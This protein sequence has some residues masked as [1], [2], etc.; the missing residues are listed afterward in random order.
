MKC[1]NAQFSAVNKILAAIIC[2]LQF[3]LT[4]GAVAQSFNSIYDFTGIPDGANPRGN[5]AA[6]STGN[7]YGTTEAGGVFDHG[8]VFELSPPVAPGSPWTETILYSF[9]GGSDGESPLGG[10]AID[11]HGNLWGTTPYGDACCGTVFKL[12]APASGDQWEFRTIHTFTGGPSDGSYPVAGVVV[13]STGNVYGITQNGGS[14]TS[15]CAPFQSG[16]GTVFKITGM[17]DGSFTETILWNFGGSGDGQLPESTPIIDAAGNLYGTTSDGGRPF[18]GRGHGTAYMLSPSNGTWAETILFTFHNRQSPGRNP[19]GALVLDKQ[20][21]FWGTSS[22]GPE[23]APGCGGFGC[24]TIFRLSPSNG[25]YIGNPLY[26]FTNQEDGA[27]PQYGLLLDGSTSTFYGTVPYSSP[28]PD[29]GAIF[30]VAKP[31]GQ[32]VYSV[33]HSFENTDGCNPKT[34]LVFDNNGNF[35]GSTTRGGSAQV[36]SVF[37]VTP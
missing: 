30:K 28:S 20:G 25:G 17:T 10:L 21:N 36:G 1:P 4:I 29:C 15:T 32:W 11:K 7:L 24:G 6:D 16:C 19:L 26:V 31:T 12:K 8:A 37:Q 23:G 3:T 34:G 9:T 14:Y 33:L 18:F 27:N 5:L 22:E 2:V 35:Y 13:D